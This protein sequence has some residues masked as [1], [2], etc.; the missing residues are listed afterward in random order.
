MKP[1]GRTPPGGRNRNARG[2]RPLP[3]GSAYGHAHCLLCGHRNPWSLKLHFAPRPNGA[4]SACITVDRRLQGYEGIVH[5]GVI[6][7]LLD[8][9]MTNCLFRHG[10]K[11]VTADLHVR[12]VESI[13]V[14]TGLD[15]CAWIVRSMPRLHLVRSELAFGGR[16]AAWAEAK[17][18]MPRFPHRQSTASVSACVLPP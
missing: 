1:K 10:V 4:V 3:I 15:I 13:P 11:A 14:G 7:A 12:F 9:A 5:G 8:A 2:A 17:F 18:T 16:V 6:A